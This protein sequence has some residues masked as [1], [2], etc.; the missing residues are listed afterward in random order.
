MIKFI[1]RKTWV[2]Y[3]KSIEEEDAALLLT[4]SWFILVLY[5]ESI[6]FFINQKP[7]TKAICFPVV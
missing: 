5:H 3:A 2:I 6:S 7:V 1:V 4:M